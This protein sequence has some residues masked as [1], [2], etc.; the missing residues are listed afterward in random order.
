MKQEINIGTNIHPIGSPHLWVASCEKHSALWLHHPSIH[1]SKALHQPHAQLSLT[2]FPRLLVISP[3]FPFL[4]R[5]ETIHEPGQATTAYG[6]P[7]DRFYQGH[8]RFCGKLKTCRPSDAAKEAVQCFFLTYPAWFG[9]FCCW[10]SR[11][12]K[13]S[14]IEVTSV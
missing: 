10:A 4:S 6:N 3:C 5:D 2:K 11:G 8:P 9:S 14:T 13:I 12:E 7:W 1:P